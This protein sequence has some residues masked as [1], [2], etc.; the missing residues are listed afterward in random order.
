MIDEAKREAYK[1][2]E[3]PRP[4]QNKNPIL[5]KSLFEFVVE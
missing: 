5:T 3:A 2:L 4:I 1:H